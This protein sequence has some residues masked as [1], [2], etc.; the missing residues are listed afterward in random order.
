M[1][2]RFGAV[3]PARRGPAPGL[4]RRR[5]VRPPRAEVIKRDLTQATIMM[6]RA[7]IRQTDPDYFPLAVAS[8]ILGGGASSRLYGRVRDEGGLAYSVWS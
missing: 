8:Y 1:T 2:T 5:R 6:G 4:A 7:A 3:G